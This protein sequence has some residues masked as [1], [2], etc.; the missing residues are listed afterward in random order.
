MTAVVPNFFIVGAA[1]S[2]TTSLYA[3]LKEH[4]EVFMPQ[5]DKEPSFF[6]SHYGLSDWEKYLSL[7]TPGKGK[8]AIGEA[9]TPYLTS[10]ES[11]RWIRN[12]LKDVRII[13]VLRN[14]IERAFSLYKWMVMHGYEWLPA[15]EVAIEQENERFADPRFRKENP[16]YFWNYMYFRSGLYYAQVKRYLEVFGHEAVRIFLFDELCSEPHHV[17]KEVCSFLGVS[18]EFAPSLSHENQSHVPRYAT[19]QYYFRMMHG[20]RKLPGLF[21]RPLR[22]LVRS[23]MRVN[24]ALGPEKPISPPV[25][26][27]LKKAYRGDVL[28]L[29]TIAKRDLSQWVAT[30]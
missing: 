7:F 4:P 8:K 29:S 20:C 24:V 6:S 30:C 3:W 15:F 28:Q 14:P 17:Y 22:R 1:R 21:R 5:N 13:I 26:A 11:A 9:S 23:A 25:R 12:E 10:P 16:Q 19:A 27:M 2:G 18:T